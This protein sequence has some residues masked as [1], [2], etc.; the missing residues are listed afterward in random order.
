MQFGIA[1]KIKNGARRIV[2]EEAE[3]A[4]VAAFSAFKSLGVEVPQ[5]TTPLLPAS[6]DSPPRD[7][8]MSPARDHAKCHESALGTHIG[9]ER[10]STEIVREDMHP[11]FSIQIKESEGITNSVNIAT[12]QEEASPLSTAVISQSLS[13][14][15]ADKGPVNACN[16][17]G[18]FNSFLDQWSSVNDFSFDLHFVKRSTKRSLT[19]FEIL[20]LAVCWE[21]SPVYYCNFPK[22]LTPSGNNESI[23]MWEEFK[24]RWSRIIGIMQ[25]KSVRKMTWNLKI[26]IHALKSPCVSCQ[27]LARL[28]LDHKTLNNIDVLDSTYVLLPPISVYSGLDICLVAWILWPDEES[29]T[30][31]NLEKV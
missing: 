11:V 23:E 20:G 15:V 8:M 1:K 31:P 29:K 19:I 14:N 3:A 10:A 28:H 4:R 2:L 16:F 30:T 21:N 25:Q 24:R 9:D 7:V 12:M 22:D 27:R 18:G 6:E 17:P 5:F 26:Q 13:R